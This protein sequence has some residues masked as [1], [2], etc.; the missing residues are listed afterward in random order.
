MPARICQRTRRRKAASSS[1]PSAVN[2]VTSAVN[3]PRRMGRVGRGS[4]PVR[5]S[6]GAGHVGGSFQA[7]M[8]SRA[9]SSST[10]GSKAWRPGVARRAARASRRRPGSRRHRPTG[11]ARSGAARRSRRRR[12]SRRGASRATSRPG[13]RRPRG[14]RG[15]VRPRVAGRRS[16]GRDRSRCPTAGRASPGD[17][18]RG[19]TGRSRRARRT[20]RPPRRPAGRTATT[21]RLK[22]EAATAAAP[23]LAEQ[24]RRPAADRPPSR[25]SR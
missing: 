1:A 25:S 13:P 17:A 9:I 3:A 4:S 12:R 11:R 20:A 14:R 18:T 8:G 5:W 7:A 10:T 23:V 15:S 22:F 21:P 2:G 24:R 19:G 16:A 6:V